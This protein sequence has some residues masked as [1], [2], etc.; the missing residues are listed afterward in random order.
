MIA[1]CTR[2]MP[3]GMRYAMTSVQ[4]ISKELEESASV[5]GAS[6]LQ[7]FR[8]VV[9]PLMTPGLVAGWTY[10][11]IVSFRE[12]SSSILLYSPGKEVLAVVLFQEYENGE[13]PTVAALGVIMVATLV[14]LILIGQ[15]IA[16][17]TSI[18]EQ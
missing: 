17:R 2:Y 8:R 14:V 10:I 9:L 12:L 11:L 7:S 5:S 15:K 4:Q 1:Y 13:F 16:G 18:S 6:W 3:Y